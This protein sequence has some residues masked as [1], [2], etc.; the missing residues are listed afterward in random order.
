[1]YISQSSFLRKA[2]DVSAS[3]YLFTVVFLAKVKGKQGMKAIITVFFHWACQC[4][5]PL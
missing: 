1:M 3:G 4:R 2:R 5:V